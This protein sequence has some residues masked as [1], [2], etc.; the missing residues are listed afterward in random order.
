MTKLLHQEQEMNVEQKKII[1]SV[2]YWLENTIIEFNFC[3]F[4]KKEFINQTIHYQVSKNEDL[5]CRL[6]SLENELLR[7]DESRQLETT[8]L[9][10]PKGL[11]SFFDYL[12]FLSMANELLLELNYEGVYQLA[13]FHPDYCFED[14]K[15]NDASNYTNRSPFPIIHIL[16]E[17]S[18]ER[19]LNKYD[20]PEDIPKRNIILSQ[21]KGNDFFNKILNQAVNIGKV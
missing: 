16:R 19:V 20:K 15:Q 8:L 12:D 1:D 7:L 21:S 13:S 9:I 4:A 6:T 5:Q 10:Y 11:E 14:A 3:P 2:K 17:E 18:L